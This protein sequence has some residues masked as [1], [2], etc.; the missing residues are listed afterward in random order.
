MKA[1]NHR[2]RV[3]IQ[4]RN[5]AKKNRKKADLYEP[6]MKTFIYK[7]SNDPL[8]ET[9]AKEFNKNKGRFIYCK[10]SNDLVNQLIQ[11]I[12]TNNWT[13]I[14]CTEEKIK[15]YLATADIKPHKKLQGFTHAEVGITSCEA[16]VAR[17]GSII[18]SS[19]GETSRTLSVF[20]PVHIVIAY[21]DQVFFDLENAISF[22]K[23][24]YTYKFPSM[25]SIISGPSRTADIEKT[26]VFG[27]HGPKD[28]YCFYL[29]EK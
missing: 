16:L 5:A 17:T 14:F 3:L 24:K 7:K 23:E 2:E 29:S 15:N 11:L 20:P 26:L 21:F 10:N 19:A 6:D 8:A 4:I 28:I 13:D 25:I 18:V 22:L 9:F 1:T 27:A 12:T